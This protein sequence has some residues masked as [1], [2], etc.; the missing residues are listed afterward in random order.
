[1][2]IL[3]IAVS[4]Y[5]VYL[6]LFFL[7]P[8]FFNGIII[9]SKPKFFSSFIII[10]V[11]SL[12]AYLTAAIIPNEWISNRILHIFSGGF[13]SFLVCFLVV[14]DTKLSINKFQFFFLGF[15]IVIALG[16]ANEIVEFFLQNYFNLTF[17]RT[18]NDTWLDLISNIIGAILAAAI[19][20]PLVKADK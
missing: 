17:A 10:V 9:K 7:F 13:I 19:F 14:K 11:A 5:I 18:I 16:A 4:L 20:V 3:L 8:F 6:F 1:M 12:I 2:Y 15:L